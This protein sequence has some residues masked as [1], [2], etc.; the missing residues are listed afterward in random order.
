MPPLN[1]FFFSL[2]ANWWLWFKSIAYT[3]CLAQWSQKIFCKVFLHVVFLKLSS[4]K[5]EILWN[6]KSPMN[7]SWKLS[8]PD[9]E[10]AG[11]DEERGCFWENM[12]SLAA[13]LRASQTQM[14]TVHCTHTVQ[15]QMCTV[16]CLVYTQYTLQYNLTLCKLKK[17]LSAASTRPKC[18]KYGC[19]SDSKVWTIHTFFIAKYIS[20][21]ETEKHIL[22]E[23][24]TRENDVEA[25]PG[26][27]AI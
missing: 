1:L 19:S 24:F 27:V 12:V 17:T 21:N 8:E 4:N 16:H 14:C 9:P 6:E 13:P 20:V 10:R 3:A 18:E 15:T 22:S 11:G 23:S 26:V 2:L 5:C 7:I 25:G